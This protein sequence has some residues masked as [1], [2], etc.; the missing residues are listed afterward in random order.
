M[1]CLDTV[2]QPDHHVIVKN[3]TYAGPIKQLEIPSFKHGRQMQLCNYLIRIPKNVLSIDCEC[4]V[5]LVRFYS[6]MKPHAQEVMTKVS[7][8][9]N[10]SPS[11]LTE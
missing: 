8:T 6:L 5:L 3:S 1:K 10:K 9:F 4:L 2:R 7:I 11:I